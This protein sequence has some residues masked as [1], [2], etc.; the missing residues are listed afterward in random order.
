MAQH[1]RMH[2][3]WHLR[4]GYAAVAFMMA[5]SHE[6][7]A[8]PHGKRLPRLTQALRLLRRSVQ[9]RQKS[10]NR[11]GESS[12]YRTVCWMFLCPR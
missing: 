4:A 6:S 8:F 3:K 10:L 12:L 9:S 5:A 1:V 2:A 7:F 11:F